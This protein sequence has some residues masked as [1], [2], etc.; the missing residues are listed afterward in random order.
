[1]T[2]DPTHEP[3]QDG[4][5]RARLTPG[6]SRGIAVVLTVLVVLALVAVAVQLFGGAPLT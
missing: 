6:L 1:M 4:A 5:A 2:D 3:A